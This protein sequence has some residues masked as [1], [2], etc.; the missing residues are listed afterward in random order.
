MGG[1]LLLLVVS[2]ERFVS[3]LDRRIAIMG[4]EIIFD[5]R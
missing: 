2:P 4:I 5:T 3:F 1:L